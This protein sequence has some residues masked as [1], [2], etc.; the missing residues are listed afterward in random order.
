MKDNADSNSAGSPK[1]APLNGHSQSVPPRP[2]IDIWVAF[3]ILGRRWHWLMLAGCLFAGGFFYLGLQFIKPKFTAEALM[4][5]EPPTVISE[6]LKPVEM[7][8]ETFTGL[9]RSPDL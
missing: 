4:K 6:A 5:R 9:I 7:T 3:D 2:P 8:P 1:A